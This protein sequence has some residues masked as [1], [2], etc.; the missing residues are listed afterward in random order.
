MAL[1][2]PISKLNELIQ[3]IPTAVLTT[4]RP[5][6]S[7]HSRPM[8]PQQV[9]ASGTFWFLTASNTEKVEAVRTMQR[10]NLSFANPAADRY[11]SVSGYCELV[12]NGAK[13]KELWRPEYKAWLPTGLDDPDLVLM[14]IVV[15]QAEYWDSAQGR[16][17]ELR[18]FPNELQ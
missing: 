9:D 10:V 6:S 18:G 14:R 17:L 13:A 7:L 16:M 1:T 2:D 8:A 12:R 5:D 15:Q 3:G 4:V 11:V